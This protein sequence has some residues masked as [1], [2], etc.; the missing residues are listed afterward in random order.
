MKILIGEVLRPQGIQG[1]IKL[2]NFSDG[3]EQV[4]N[5]KNV[6]IDDKKFSVMKISQRDNALF[7][8]LGGIY[9]RDT[10][11]L[12]RGKNVYCD[13]EEL[14]ISDN[15]FFIEDII[16]CSLKLSSGK[17][18]GTVKEV[19]SSSTDIFVLDTQEGEAYMPFVKELNAQI[20]IENKEI[21]VDA[22]KFTEVVL[23]KEQK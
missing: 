11:E 13:R 7:M 10:A 5:I 23:Y 19:T 12:Y 2:S 20:N 1:E 18:I 14:N 17:T 15:S 21:T 4:K 8:F 16:G 9:D 6:Y 22:K 3:Y